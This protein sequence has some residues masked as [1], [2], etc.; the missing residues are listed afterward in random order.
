MRNHKR[1]A[2]RLGDMFI[3]ADDPSIGKS[4]DL[5]G[6]YCYSEI[7]LILNMVNSD[8]IVLD[9]GA[10]IGSH[11]LALAPHV[12]N[13]VA[14]EADKEN[15]ELLRMNCSLRSDVTIK[16]LA[17][18]DRIG[19]TSTKFNFGKTE[20]DAGKLDVD[21]TTLDALKFPKVDF[22]KIDVEGMELDVL[23]GGR[24]LITQLKPNMLIEMQDSFMNPSVFNFL[25]DLEYK[26]WWYPVATF[27]AGNYKNNQNNVFGKQHGVINWFASQHPHT[28]TQELMPVVDQF[29]TIERAEHTRR[30]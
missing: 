8:S 22:I 3:F 13:V 23:E 24:D 21:M 4:L 12:K 1:V 29:D 17:L 16:H 20:L 5:Y 10:N 15:V 11:C 14:F 2:T 19:R 28:V 26:I 25:N 7:E 18:S 9:V 27:N 30:S 6:E